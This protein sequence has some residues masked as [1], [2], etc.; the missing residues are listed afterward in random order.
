MLKRSNGCAVARY[1]QAR[2]LGEE[3]LVLIHHA[4]PCVMF[5]RAGLGA[6]A[7]GVNQRAVAQ[8]AL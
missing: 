4:V 2:H 6:V 5:A 1:W 8:D 3:L 7:I